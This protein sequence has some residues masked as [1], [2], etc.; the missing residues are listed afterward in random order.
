MKEIKVY[1]AEEEEGII[2]NIMDIA[3]TL[4]CKLE[5]LK[6]VFLEDGTIYD[7]GSNA[8]ILL[9]LPR[10]NSRQHHGGYKIP[11]VIYIYIYR[12]AVVTDGRKEIYHD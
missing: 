10:E 6:M 11:L 1:S 9:V 12:V 2:R 7:W 4:E 5:R 3:D 8:Y